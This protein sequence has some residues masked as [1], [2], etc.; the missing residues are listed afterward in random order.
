MKFTDQEHSL[1]YQNSTK[2]DVV[3]NQPYQAVIWSSAS[4]VVQGKNIQILFPETKE[5]T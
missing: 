3:N 5:A 1:I 4:V 2:A